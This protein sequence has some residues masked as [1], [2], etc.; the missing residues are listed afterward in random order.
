MIFYLKHDPKGNP[1]AVFDSIENDDDSMWYQGT[2]KD[3]KNAGYPA[4]SLQDMM[5]NCFP[6]GEHYVCCFDGYE[7]AVSL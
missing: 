5:A 2:G 4:F 3:I 6:N 7:N 1:Y